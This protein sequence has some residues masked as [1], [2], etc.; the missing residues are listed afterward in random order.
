[1]NISFFFRLSDLQ[2]LF[3]DLPSSVFN[4]FLNL[5]LISPI[6]FKSL[7]SFPSQVLFFKHSSPLHFFTLS[8]ILVAFGAGVKADF[9]VFSGFVAEF[10]FLWNIFL[11]AFPT[12]LTTFLNLFFNNLLEEV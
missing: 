1:L 6:I 7:Q 5:E 4:H 2:N 10:D 8:K 12:F 11:I 3:A 9:G